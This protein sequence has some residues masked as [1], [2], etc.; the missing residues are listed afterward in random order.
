MGYPTD[1]NEAL[2]ALK[3]DDLSLAA[4]AEAMLWSL[5]CRSERC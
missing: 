1:E 5:W 3:G 4:T 2:E